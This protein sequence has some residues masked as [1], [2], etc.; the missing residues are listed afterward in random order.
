MLEDIRRRER[1]EASDGQ[2]GFLADIC[3]EGS[4]QHRGWLQAQL[5]TRCSSRP[6]SSNASIGS[7][8]HHLITHG[9]VLDEQG[10]KMSRSLGNIISPMTVINSG[11]QEEGSS[12]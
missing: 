2:S 11:G 4:D 6:L 3:L 7:P 12:L 5:L 10:K 1:E 9:M 8:Y